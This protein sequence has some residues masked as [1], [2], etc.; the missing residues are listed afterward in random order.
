MSLEFNKNN[1]EL[2]TPKNLQK[3]NIKHNTTQEKIAL[4][5]QHILNPNKIETVDSK[6][7]NFSILTTKKQDKIGL[8][9][10]K[11]QKI[12]DNFLI[13][14]RPSFSQYTKINPINIQITE[15]EI[16]NKLYAYS[17]QYK[18]KFVINNLLFSSSTQNDANII[19]IAAD[20]LNN[21]KK[22]L[23]NG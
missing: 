2:I 14:G 8:K 11:M 20:G 16:Q 4:Q 9:K 19:F 21:A 12:I 7:H 3:F 13:E 17:K 5:L 22:A 15:S 23:I 1:K 6:I 10:K 18:Y